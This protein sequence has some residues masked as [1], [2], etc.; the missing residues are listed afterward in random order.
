MFTEPVGHP[1]KGRRLPRDSPCMMHFTALGS[2][3]GAS[4]FLK[5]DHG[6]HLTGKELKLREFASLAQGPKAG[7]GQIGLEL[8]S[9]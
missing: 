1:G 6:P 4:C 7:H 2:H 8:G 3:V 9:V 5:R